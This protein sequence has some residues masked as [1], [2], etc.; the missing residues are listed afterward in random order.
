VVLSDSESNAVVAKPFIGITTYLQQAQTG[1]W[2][3]RAAFLPEEYFAAV[4]RAGG[5]PLLLPP[6]PLHGGVAEQVIAH[7]DGLIIAG[8]LDVEPSRYGAEASPKSDPRA[9]SGTIGMTLCWPKRSVSIC[10]SWPSA[11]ASRCSM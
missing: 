10:R 4:E 7:I 11:G 3:V 5:I 8:G 1:V 2:D 9:A 6:Q